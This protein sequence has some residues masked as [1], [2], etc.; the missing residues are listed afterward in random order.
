MRLDPSSGAAQ[1][2]LTERNEHCP[3]VT[4]FLIWQVVLTERD[5]HKPM[6]FPEPSLNL[7]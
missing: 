3:H 1:V 7:P 4:T 2:V 5:E 6:P